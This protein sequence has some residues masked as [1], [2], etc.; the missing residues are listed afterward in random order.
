M[1]Q[2][3]NDQPASELLKE[4]EAEKK[5]LIKEG[6]IR[7]QEALQLIKSEKNT[8]QLPEGWVRASL[9]ELGNFLGGKT[10][11]TNNS[12]FW[13]GTIPWV[14]A[15]DMKMAIIKDSEDH[16]TELGVASG[17]AKIPPQ[18]ILMVV[19]SGIL[20]RTFPVAINSVFCTINQDLKALVLFPQ[21]YP[22]YVMLML[23]GFENFILSHLTKTGM[24]V[25]S[26]M[27]SEFSSH[28]FPL[29]P[30]AEQKRIVAKVDQ[31]MEL[32]NSLEQQLQDSTRKQTAI[33]D[34]VLATM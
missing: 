11:S 22:E 20:R 23:R 18:S 2:D 1:P 12:S 3:A 9:L 7:K 13:N 28:K 25:E 4:I 6:K 27:F 31:L 14:S 24:T 29:P 17:L 10:P 21:V 8:F 34:A 19:R 16:I 5:K 26:V 32:C 30:L 33:L 15:K